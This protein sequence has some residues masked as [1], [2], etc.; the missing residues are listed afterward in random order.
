MQV[1][2]INFNL[3]LILTFNTYN[4]RT[5]EVLLHAD[6]ILRNVLLLLRWF[7]LVFSS[8]FSVLLHFHFS[9]CTSSH[10][11]DIWKHDGMKSLRKLA[12]I[13]QG[14]TPFVFDAS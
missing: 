10:Y 6:D 11:T 2:K 3:N 7:A 1:E 13:L 8:Y 14:L 4:R 12:P 5:R 9:F